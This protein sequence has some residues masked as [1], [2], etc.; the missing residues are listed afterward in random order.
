MKLFADDILLY[1]PTNTTQECVAQHAVSCWSD[2]WQLALKPAKYESLAITN[3][4]FN[5]LHYI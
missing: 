3:K 1:A 2:R 4:C 5:I